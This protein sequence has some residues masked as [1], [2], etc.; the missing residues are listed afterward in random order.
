MKQFDPYHASKY[1]TFESLRILEKPL[2][3]AVS[4]QGF[5]TP[6]KIQSVGLP[7]ILTPDENTGFYPNIIAQAHHGSGKTATFVLSMLS[8]IKENNPLLQCLC[9]CH[10]RELAKQTYHVTKDLGRFMNELNIVLCVPKEVLPKPWRGQIAIGTPG[11]IL[12]LFD[13]KQEEIAKFLKDFVMLVIDEADEFL[14]HSE[15]RI[16]NYPRGGMY[17]SSSR[18]PG[19]LKEQ[20]AQIVDIIKHVTD[21]KKKASMFIVFCNIS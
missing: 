8:R 14:R 20:L 2:L 3:D 13:D 21:D 4:R 17:K 16:H 5:V 7:L 15:Q 18:Q 1:P 12:N 11:S 6:S 10:S 19:N 9:V